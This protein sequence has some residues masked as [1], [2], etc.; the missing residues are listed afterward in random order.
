MKKG[1]RHEEE[2]QMDYV[3]GAFFVSFYI[4]G[5]GNA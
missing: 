5:N 3:A 1:M 4:D 2:K